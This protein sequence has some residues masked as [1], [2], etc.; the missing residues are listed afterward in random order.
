MDSARVTI[1]QVPVCRSILVSG[2]SENTTQ[3]AIELCFES[4]RNNGG[5][6]ETV[7]FKPK[8][9]RAVVVFQ[10]ST[11]QNSN[12][13]LML[14][15]LFLFKMEKTTTYTVSFCFLVYGCRTSFDILMTKVNMRKYTHKKNLAVERRISGIFS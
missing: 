12:A 10:N 11:G 8:S 3:D 1:Q 14:V 4:P 15:V 7:R 2:I 13:P 6:V 9:D 5:P